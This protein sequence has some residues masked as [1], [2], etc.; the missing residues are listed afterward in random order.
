MSKGLT[1]ALAT[2]TFIAACQSD[3]D[4]DDQRRL[5]ALLA[6]APLNQLPPGSAATARAG[7]TA[8]A[9]SRTSGHVVVPG[10]DAIGAWEFD[11]CNPGRTNLSDSSPHD[12]TAFRS[13]G[14]TCT[15]GTNDT[16][17][18]AIAAPE[19]IVYVPDQPD[20]TLAAG[21]TVAAWFKPTSLNGTRTLFRKRDKGTSS[22]A[23]VLDRGK[24]EFV[25]SLGNHA[26]ISAKSPKKAAPDAFQH[27]AATYDGT[28]ARLYLDGVEVDHATKTGSIP[29]G[30][31]PLLI[32]NDGAE[33]R[34][35]G[36]IDGAVFATHALTAD[37]VLALTCLPDSPS[38][39]VTP[40][41]P[42]AG[43]GET[44]TIDVALTNHNSPVCAPITFTYNTE[45]AGPLLTVNPP[46]FKPMPG[47]P[48]PSGGTTHFTVTAA[49]A[50]TA[51]AGALLPVAFTVTEPTTPFSTFQLFQVRVTEPTGCQVDPARE[52]M[53]TSLSVVDDPVRTS[54][55]PGSS[56][57]RNG[58][59]T[60]KRLMEDMA[61]SAA[62]APA[63]AE[64]MLSSL[65]VPQT[66]NG[67]QV[68]ARP[69]MQDF[70]ARWPRTPDGALD[71]AQAP[72]L[73]QAI[74]NRFDLRDLSRG[75][76][77]E[78]RFVFAF[79]NRPSPFPLQ[80]TLILEYKL[81]AASDQDVLDW[82]QS[83]HA[84]QTLPLGE[85]YNAALQAITERFT[86]RGVRPGHP[87]GSAI[88]AVRT[89]E[90]DFAFPFWELR[91][92]HLSATTGLLEPAPLELTP[93]RG[94]NNTPTLA[95]YIAANQAAILLDKHT[96]PEQFAGESFQA[97]AVFNLLDTWL[98]PGIAPGVS[99]EARHHFAV[100]TC[101]GCHSVAETNTVFLQ[102]V[103]RFPGSESLLSPFLT[104]TTVID[105][106]TRLPRTFNDL[107]RRKADLEAVVCAEAPAAATTLR[108]GIQRVH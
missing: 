72:L 19:D 62:D 97:G 88:N 94:F 63:M 69:L 4:D 78:G 101:N 35:A 100:N 93:D 76:A 22:F 42:S 75:D 33:R 37:Q 36:A 90:I 61:P 91:E 107:A 70:L 59:W 83:F 13:I 39:E 104:G 34:F 73:L 51:P 28:T 21:V 86:G 16:P 68:L 67:F 66:I 5:Q 82:A 55:A 31:G 1:C 10:A 9:D 105:P 80:A 92:F 85:D 41:A 8:A 27:V 96:V 45:F 23:L 99:G 53:I 65:T 56:D 7:D 87:N 29:P 84:L 18:I 38:I 81:P 106:V 46:P 32:G 2:L 25:V 47:E 108:K 26:A 44:A 77:G 60:F 95:S 71:L 98:A 3:D 49:V 17:A 12:N 64:A 79:M 54:F 102:I 24:F 15:G 50:T 40:S 103:P 58:A 57:P 6:D 52:L 11:D 20:F 43:P 74:V 89:N 48:V 30:P 14:V